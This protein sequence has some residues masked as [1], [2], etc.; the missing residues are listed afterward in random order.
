MGDFTSIFSPI[1][2]IINKIICNSII[3]LSFLY[4]DICKEEYGVMNNTY[5]CKLPHK[6][7]VTQQ[8]T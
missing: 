4:K 3:G 8:D 7:E 5:L 1:N 2:T 6:Y